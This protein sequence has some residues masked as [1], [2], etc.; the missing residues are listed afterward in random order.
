MQVDAKESKYGVI[1]TG[2]DWDSNS[3]LLTDHL[4]FYY[5]SGYQVSETQFIH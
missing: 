5:Q 3:N 2:C 1:K 4:A